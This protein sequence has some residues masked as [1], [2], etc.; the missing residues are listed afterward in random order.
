[1]PRSARKPTSKYRSPKAPR[2][3]RLATV[4]RVLGFGFFLAAALVG[5]AAAT[6]PTQLQQ[7]VIFKSNLPSGSKISISDLEQISLPIAEKLAKYELET[8]DLIGKQLNQN[9]AAGELAALTDVSASASN[10]QELTLSFDQKFLP[11]RLSQGDVFDLWI[12]PQDLTGNSLG[13]AQLIKAALPVS[14]LIE[15]SSTLSAEIALTFFIAPTEVAKV[16]D[17]VS[18]GKPYLVRR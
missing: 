1:M 4:P 2:G 7:A 5:V 15:G 9:V 13:S 10:L 8:T 17:A 3:L 18:N 11:P 16:L 12:V 14:G 6:A